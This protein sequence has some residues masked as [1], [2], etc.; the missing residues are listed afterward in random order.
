MNKLLSAILLSS[1]LILASELPISHIETVK[2]KNKLEPSG[3]TFFKNDLFIVSD[4][5]RVCNISKN[6]CAKFR[7]KYDFEGI[8]T[9][10]E[11]LYVSVEGKDDIYYI[12]DFG[13]IS[14]KYKIPRTYNERVILPKGGDGIE[15][16]TFMFSKNGYRYF[17]I[18]NQSKKRSGYDSS[19]IIFLKINKYGEVSIIKTVEPHVTDLSGLFYKNGI[20]YVLSDKENK[21]L[22]INKEGNIIKEYDN[23]PGEDQEGVYIKDN[24]L[25]I[26]QD[27]GNILKIFLEKEI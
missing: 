2:I 7:K 21:L 16:M 20:L 1:T 18:T 17:A 11:K 12:N 25:F 27:S 13:E 15:G 24:I 9:D 14:E 6:I 3:I 19:M 5:G 10:G 22:L 4:N 8:S 23:L 26:A